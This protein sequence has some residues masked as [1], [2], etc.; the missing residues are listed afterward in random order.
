MASL[1]TLLSIWNLQEDDE[2]IRELFF[3]S[4]SNISSDLHQEYWAGDTFSS[5]LELQCCSSCNSLNSSKSL[6]CT[7]CGKSLLGEEG[8]RMKQQ[9]KKKQEG[10]FAQN[11]LD[12]L[13][14]DS[15]RSSLEDIMMDNSSTTPSYCNGYTY[16]RKWR[17][18]S[19]YHMWQK[20][21]SLKKLSTASDPDYDTH[22]V[23]N[24]LAVDSNSI[25][26]QERPITVTLIDLPNEIL[27]FILS[28]LSP[29]DVAAFGL[30]CERFRHVSMLDYSKFILCKK[31][32][33]SF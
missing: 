29:L 2:N 32:Y 3:S 30:V 1:K 7:E 33:S 13:S 17:S 21:S 18:S 6:W 11:L 25:T 8:R 28:F 5:H 31:N 14:I 4:K 22:T 15:H 26:A 10:G 20:P 27:L 19:R 9:A 12:D 16:K 24:T 23:M